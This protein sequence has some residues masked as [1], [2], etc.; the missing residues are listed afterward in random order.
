MRRGRERDLE[1][2]RR[3]GERARLGDDLADDESPVHVRAEDGGDV[4]ERTAP[5]T[6]AAS[7]QAA[8]ALATKST[9]ICGRA[10]THRVS[11]G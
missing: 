10:L 5:S 4:V 2:V 11:I 6:A 8:Q 1:R 7:S 9:R 3:G